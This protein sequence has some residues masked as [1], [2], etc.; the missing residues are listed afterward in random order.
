MIKHISIIYR[1]QGKTHEETVRYWKEVHQNVVK[2]RLPGLKKYVGNFPVEA[3]DDAMKQP[4]GGRQSKCD[5]I[6]ELHFETLADLHAAM[7]S[8]G[9]NSSERAQ[10]SATFMDYSRMEYVVMEE[11]VATLPK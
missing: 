3:P 11:V 10:S 9:W 1:P 4:G 2:A 6:V 5:A 8:P 7:A